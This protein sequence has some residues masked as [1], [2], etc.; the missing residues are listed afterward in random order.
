[1][2]EEISLVY[3]RKKGGNA[4][5]KL[6]EPGD[7]S[8]LS[9]Q[10]PICGFLGEKGGNPLGGKSRLYLGRGLLYPAQWPCRSN[11]EVTWSGGEMSLNVGG[12]RSQVQRPLLGPTATGGDASRANV[13]T[14]NDSTRREKPAFRT[15]HGGGRVG[16]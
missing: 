8:C 14:V 10:G 1:L 16:E 13:T 4:T 12:E 5:T 6:V 9:C 3:D 15:N 7:G 11:L 2:L